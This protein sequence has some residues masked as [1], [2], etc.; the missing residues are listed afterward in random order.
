MIFGPRRT[1]GTTSRFAA[2]KLLWSG[3]ALLLIASCLPVLA[4][5]WWLSDLC[6][7]FRVQTAFVAAVAIVPL[8]WRDHWA[9]GIAALIFV[10]NVTGLAPLFAAP[11][12]AATPPGAEKLRIAFSNVF[13][14]NPHFDRVM[15]FAIDSRADVVVLAEITPQWNAELAPLAHY[16]PYRH[17][18]Y[19][20][21]QRR[22]GTLLLSRLPLESAATV[23][24]GRTGDPAVK[25]DIRAGEKIFHLI[26]AHPTWPLWRIATHNRDAQYAQLATLA[27]AAGNAT[28][29]VGDFNATAFSPAYERFVTASGLSDASQG[30]WMPTWPTF[31]PPFYMQIDHALI[32]RDLHV[33]AIERGPG[34]GSDHRPIVLD[35]D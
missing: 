17:Y 29:V 11:A 8:F 30:R 13:Y 3:L 20:P 14:A 34:V 33:A 31:F 10:I 27:R 35:V 25:A 19:L 9:G 18:A 32:S 26:G 5:D 7:H 12:P 21:G 6:S 24:F 2:D 16:F 23:G 1:G 15:H 28:I 22:A 4:P